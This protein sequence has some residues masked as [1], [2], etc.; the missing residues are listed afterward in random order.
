MLTYPK[1]TVCSAYAKRY[2]FEPRDFAKKGIL[3]SPSLCSN[4]NASQSEI[5]HIWPFKVKNGNASKKWDTIWG[6]IK[7]H[8][9]VQFCQ[10]SVFR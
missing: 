10:K 7:Q 2:E 5:R 4:H 9:N 3:T 1:S 8:N 6:N